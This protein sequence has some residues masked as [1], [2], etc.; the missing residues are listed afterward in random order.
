[1]SLYGWYSWPSIF[2]GFIGGYLLDNIFGLRFGTALACF[3]VVI[4]QVLLSMGKASENFSILVLF[5]SVRSIKFCFQNC[6][7]L[8][9]SRMT[10]S[11]CSEVDFEPCKGAFLGMIELCYFGRFIFGCGG[12]TLSVAQK[13]FIA[14]WFDQKSLN[15]VLGLQLSF[16]RIGEYKLILIVNPYWQI[17]RNSSR[18]I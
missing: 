4:G 3:F 18:V 2:L 6:I 12:E 13:G 16:A 9:L 1:M 11:F 14:Q 10:V 8:I 15:F 5:R 17:M 7:I